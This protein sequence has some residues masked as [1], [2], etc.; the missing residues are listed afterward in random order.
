M[1]IFFATDIHGS[2]VCWRKFLNAR[3]VYEPDAMIIGGDI[4]GKVLIPIVGD[5]SGA[6]TAKTN[7][8]D[9]SLQGEEE[10]RAYEREIADVGSYTVRRSAEQYEELHR[11]PEG[12]DEAF[13]DAVIARLEAWMELAAE[14]LSDSDIPLYVSGGNDDYQEIDEVLNAAA[15][16]QCPD[17][18][19]VE[20]GPFDLLSFG[21][22]NETPWECPRDMSEEALTEV[23]TGL[24]ARLQG[25][26]PGIFNL[27]VPPH[28]TPLDEAPLLDENQRPTASLTGTEMAPVG[29]TAVRAI[30]EECQPLLSLHGH[31]HESRAAA[32]IGK[33]TILNPGSE[34]SQGVLR[35]VI[36]DV[37]ARKVRRHQ[38]ITG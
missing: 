27:H 17:R 37:D 2:E 30:I 19:V 3:A 5:G 12:V 34:Y 16:V 9:K 4:T 20:L 6:W 11:D 29:S 10:L 32:K 26:R 21:A 22:A 36:V 38:F 25:D 1:R 18:D 35:A 15:R 13:H 33:T 28:G 23:Y 14:R 8:G 31:V 24:A 7:Y